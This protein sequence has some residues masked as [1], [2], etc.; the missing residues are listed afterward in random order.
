MIIRTI[1]VGVV[2]L[3][4]A[5]AC[6]QG[7][8][9]T[10]EPKVGTKDAPSGPPPTINPLTGPQAPLT[11]KERRGVAY[12]R[13]W[14]DN[15]DMPARGEDGGV[16]FVFGATL[17]TVVCAPL[18]VCDLVLQAGET[19]ND[20]NVGD[21]VRWQITPATQGTGEATI[22]HV[23]IK[24]TDIGLI[25]NL[26]ITT[27]R[28]AYTIKLVSRAEDWM[29]RV[30]FSYPDD[31]RALWTA[32]GQ[33]RAAREEA[34]AAAMGP[35]EAAVFDFG[36]AVSGDS[37]SWRPVRVFASG[38]K[39]YIEFPRGIGAGELPTL[40]ALGDDGGLFTE[41]SKQL[42]NYRFVHG[43]FEVDKLLTRAA[44]ISG[45]GR[46]QTVVRIERQGGW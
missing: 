43:R 38:A 28:R 17:P 15:A 13:Q 42:V 1:I 2:V 27:N 7:W 36:Y 11:R 14:T 45:V 31:A 24:P 12:G 26:V 20:L 46:D 29:P 32:H 18:Y 33:A 21:S 30:G 41:P 16:T 34:A 9:A 25:T 6:A 23:M 8:T 19:V 44:L 3:G 5:P 4:A 37:P 39:T 40:V 22:T 10:V 35:G